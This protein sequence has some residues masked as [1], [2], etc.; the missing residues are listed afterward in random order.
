MGVGV[1]SLQ[2]SRNTQSVYLDLIFIHDE[3]KQFPV[4]PY[5]WQINE[6]NVG[7]K[8]FNS[9]GDEVAEVVA[10]NR[11][12]WGSSRNNFSTTLKIDV[13][14]YAEKN[15]YV[16]EGKT[17]LV[18]ETISFNLGKT[19]FKGQI[20]NI[21]DDISQK[22]GAFEEKKGIVKIKLRSLEEWHAKALVG[23]K[24]MN[25][26]GKL[27]AEEVHIVIKPSEKVVTNISG[28]VL[29]R[30]DPLKKDV[31]ITLQLNSVLCDKLTCYFQGAQPLKIGHDFIANTNRSVINTLYSDGSI[32]DF[33]IQELNE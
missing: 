8:A 19:K 12:F 2:F 10:V 24:V 28:E 17:L 16:F 29:L 5:A 33:Q 31:E 3:D 27:L 9:F 6:I 23:A 7:D 4:P 15:N 26:K 14:Y 25:D 18:G 20:Q 30:E 1:F 13:L 11:S 22:H 21:Y 32:V